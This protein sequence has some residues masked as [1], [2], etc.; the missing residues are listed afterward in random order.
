MAVESTAS[1][2]RRLLFLTPFSPRLDATNG[3]A[4]AI[5]QLVSRLAERHDVAL[6][7]IRA[8]DDPPV[9]DV[10]RGRCQL[11]E[12]F[13]RR[14][15]GRTWKERWSRRARLLSAL[16]RGHPM[17]VA[18]SYVAEFAARVRQVAETWSPDVIQMEYHVMSQYRRAL[19]SSTAPVVLTQYEPGSAAARDTVALHRGVMRAIQ[20][21]DAWAWTRFERRALGAVDAVVTFT[22]RDR[23]ETL[24][25]QPDAPVTCIPLATEVPS[26][27]LSAAGKDPPSIVFIGNFVHPPNV[28]AATR[29]VV[30]IFPRLEH[31]HP[32]SILYIVGDGP[33][34]ELASPPRERVIV[35]GR[36]PDVTPYLDAAAVIAVPIRTGGGMRVKV[37]EALA[38]G[39]AVVASSRALEGLDVVDGEHALVAETDAEFAD[40]IGR[41]LADRDLRVALAERARQW[42]CTN[43]RWDHSIE[44]YEALYEAL[45][46]ESK[47]S[48]DEL[49]GDRDQVAGSRPA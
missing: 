16:A 20:R 46:R 9:D 28:D 22:E 18:D 14:G 13:A 34:R 24:R 1:S 37:L 25:V 5:A 39:K 12:E 2:T 3:G 19:A 27:P 17:W 11:V 38:A 41:L 26:K 31:S 33:P 45:L 23:L 7:A 44:S 47:H 49:G 29:L 8:A 48:P 32:Q 10:L 21:L 43:V 42:A 36:V 4:R 40:A 6:L 35:S 15:V 30:D